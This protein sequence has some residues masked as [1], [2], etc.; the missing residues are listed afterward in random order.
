MFVVLLVV[1]SMSLFVF[2]V[3]SV[4]SARQA[5]GARKPSVSSFPVLE[6][7]QTKAMTCPST[8][9]AHTAVAVLLACLAFV[10]AHAYQPE[11]IV[12]KRYVHEYHALWKKTNIVL[13]RCNV[14]DVVQIEDGTK[15]FATDNVTLKYLRESAKSH[16]HSSIGE[17]T[18]YNLVDYHYHYSSHSVP[19]HFEE[20]LAYTYK[21]PKPGYEHLKGH[22]SFVRRCVLT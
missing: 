5:F 12:G 21:D 1:R 7:R 10:P 16:T 2:I 15:F 11:D 6:T 8:S 18:Y 14:K 13:A 19:K 17:A 3:P 4:G 9:A 22:Y 20:G